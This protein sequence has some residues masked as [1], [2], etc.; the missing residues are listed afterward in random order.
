MIQKPIPKRDAQT[1]GFINSMLKSADNKSE[2]PAQTRFGDVDPKD[3][4]GVFKAIQK[5]KYR[6]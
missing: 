6:Q 4:E 3:I 5:G 2:T 1:D